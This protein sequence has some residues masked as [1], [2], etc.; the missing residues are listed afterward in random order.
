M[1]VRRSLRIPSTK[2]THSAPSPKHAHSPKTSPTKSYFH[3]PINPPLNRRAHTKVI[4]MST[5]RPQAL[6]NP[7]FTVFL[8]ILF[9]S[10]LRFLTVCNDF[11]RKPA[12]PD[13]DAGEVFPV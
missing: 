12:E 7:L 8:L 6:R 9:L 2:D 5:F 1:R 3:L 10:P 11:R 13:C 4:R